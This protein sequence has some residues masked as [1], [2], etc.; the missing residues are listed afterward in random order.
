V[1]HGG[2]KHKIEICG[3]KTSRRPWHIRSCSTEEEEEEEEGGG[4]GGGGGGGE[5]EEEETLTYFKKIS[6]IPQHPD[7]FRV[8]ASVLSISSNISALQRKAPT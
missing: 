1:T 3:V 4:G 5:E 7:I 8:P 2:R 6:S